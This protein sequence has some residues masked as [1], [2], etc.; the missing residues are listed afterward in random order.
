MAG[1]GRIV[2]LDEELGR[3]LNAVA[4]ATGQSAGDL[5][6]KLIS[7]GL[8][9]WAEDFARFAEYERTG[10]YIDAEVAMAEFRQ[11]VAAKQVRSVAPFSG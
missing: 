10:E 9:D 11:A 8:D 1:D 7:R 5:A 4:T 2:E 6:A 3:R